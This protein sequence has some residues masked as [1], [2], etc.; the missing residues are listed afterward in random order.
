MD[1]RSHT[2][3]ELSGLA[4]RAAALSFVLGTVLIN[5]YVRSIERLA[6]PMS[7][8]PI[9]FS[10][11]LALLVTG[12]A[13]V[14]LA[15]GWMRPAFWGAMI[16][17]VAAALAGIE[18]MLTQSGVP[19]DPLLAAA[20]GG[21]RLSASAG[22]GLALVASLV[23]AR[24]APSTRR[25]W[26]PLATGVLGGLILALGFVGSLPHVLSQD[27][28]ARLESSTRM[29][30][31]SALGVVSLSLVYFALR[32]MFETGADR[33]AM[34]GWLPWIAGLAIAFV[35]VVLWTGLSASSARL[36][37]F[38]TTMAVQGTVSRASQLVL[39]ERL[40]AM[41]RFAARHADPTLSTRRSRAFDAETFLASQPGVRALHVLDAA[42]RAKSV[43][44]ATADER[45]LSEPAVRAVV[46]R[47]RATASPAVSDPVPVDGL[48]RM[49]VVV[50]A[51]LGRDV[52][53]TV[54]FE[55]DAATF[56]E[57]VCAVGPTGV[58]AIEVATEDG[59][60][61]FSSYD[62]GVRLGD[63]A[64]TGM[65]TGKL[66][67][68]DRLWSMKAIASLPGLAESQDSVHTLILGFGLFLSIAVALVA[69]RSDM[70]RQR[71][72][73]LSQAKRMLEENAASLATAN[74]TLGR[75]TGD[76][77]LAREQLELAM[78]G[79]RCILDSLS[80]ILVGVD[81]QGRVVEWNRGAE[82][83]FGLAMHDAKDRP[84]DELALRWDRGLVREAVGQCLA[85]GERVRRENLAVAVEGGEDRICSLTI[86][87]V[88]TSQ[89][90]GFSIIGSDVTERLALE[91]QLHQSQKLESVGTLAAGI[92]HEINTP[93]QFIGDN[94]RFMDESAGAVSGVLGLVPEVLDALHGEDD[95]A[96]RRALEEA[97]GEEDLAFLAEELPAAIG[98]SIEGVGRVA[99]IVAAMKD[100]SHPGSRTKAP[101]RLD[102]AIETTLQVSRN[103]YKYV[104]DVE[105]DFGELPEIDCHVGDLNQVFLNLIVNAAHAIRDRHEPRGTRGTIRIT[106]RRDGDHVE[107]RFSDDGKGIPE[108]LR[109]RIFDQFFTTKE[110]GRGTGLGLSI[111]H[112][113]I[114]EQHHG[115]IA[116][117]S[118]PGAGTTFVVRL[119][120]EQSPAAHAG[121]PVEVHA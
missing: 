92:A 74:E 89:G 93:I 23:V 58:F 30:G 114:V 54:A 77:R 10:T 87:P 113:V 72:A 41:R 49:V 56:L 31:Y 28:F 48:E 111:A 5:E 3:G 20:G 91:M 2:E 85:T 107:L 40:G 106:T 116:V 19:A 14:A 21:A 33:P 120:L 96:L 83:L 79:Q 118:E 105:T 75:Q 76:L 97:A 4:F 80:A 12:L 64:A 73:S 110:P 15:V 7:H 51:L 70:A 117:E 26:R 39:D 115:S 43:H 101:A 59:R 8:V 55:L 50:P 88:D 44:G 9:Q 104:A 57:D 27:V 11:A 112:S 62:S 18:F 36:Y 35:T 42:Q 98:E 102:H 109:R 1:A 37:D 13:A 95:A 71:L 6:G 65:A 66:S 108:E 84:F 82:S 94:L 38:T 90:R 34:P 16:A 60:P 22:L 121:E 52:V 25:T 53:A 63:S 69:R 68:G 17:L 24:W 103:E 45:L 100:F 67:F 78:A 29:F 47:A 119:P 46:E 81:A 32:G 61:F 99:T 86:N